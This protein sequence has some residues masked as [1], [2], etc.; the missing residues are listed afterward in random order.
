MNER[1]AIY[2]ISKYNYQILLVSRLGSDVEVIQEGLSTNV[3]MFLR[4]IIFIMV[5]F[6]FLFILSWELTLLMIGSIIPVII[7]SVFYGRMMKKA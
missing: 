2:V 7:F 1:L 6:V 5:S 3:S 4:S